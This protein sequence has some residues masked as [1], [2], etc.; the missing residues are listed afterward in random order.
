MFLQTTPYDLIQVSLKRQTDNPKYRRIVPRGHIA[1]RRQFILK[2]RGIG[3]DWSGESG[4]GSCHI[5]SRKVFGEERWSRRFSTYTGKAEGSWGR[6]KVEKTVLWVGLSLAN[7][8]AF[9]SGSFLAF[10][11]SPFV[12]AVL[13]P[14]MSSILLC[15]ILFAQRVTPLSVFTRVF[16]LSAQRCGNTLPVFIPGGCAVYIDYQY[17]RDASASC[18]FFCSPTVKTVVL[19]L[20]LILKRSFIWSKMYFLRIFPFN[21]VNFFVRRFI[22]PHPSLLKPSLRTRAIYTK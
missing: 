6:Q 13:T 10:S 17:E 4:A 15:I 20:P 19:P 2:S 18:K 21:A 3:W 16:I 8:H 22:P 11:P 9:S 7:R 14:S 5:E 1:I 12:A